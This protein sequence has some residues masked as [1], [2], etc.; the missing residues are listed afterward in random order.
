MNGGARAAAVPPEAV[1][2]AE[3]GAQAES[4]APPENGAQPEPVAPEG[5]PAPAGA[6]A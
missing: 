1:A 3:T 4:I 6:G 5:A 2:P